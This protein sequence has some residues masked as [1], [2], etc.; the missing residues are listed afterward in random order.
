MEFAGKIETALLDLDAV[1]L[2]GSA[3]PFPFQA[4]EQA[5]AK[6]FQIKKVNINSEPPRW[7]NEKPQGSLASFFTLIATPLDVPFYLSFDPAEI[8]LIL[9]YLLHHDETALGLHDSTLRSSLIHFILAST[10][11][12]LGEAHY[13][14]NL[15]IRLAA[16]ESLPPNEVLRIDFSLL[17]D[18]EVV[19]GQLLLPPPFLTK[20][21]QH[22]FSVIPSKT[23]K[24][25]EVEI[26]LEGGQA[27]V[28]SEQWKSLKLGDILLLDSCTVSPN[29][30]QGLVALHLEGQTLMKGE[31]TDSGLQL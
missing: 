8:S 3:P 19:R 20:W 17:F 14:S 18:T 6:F 5:L 9:K 15:K 23:S 25:I 31:L 21:R 27:E 1:P 13:P 10:L 24:L 2:L 28:S 30:G 22:Y 7:T 11:A 16:H 12:L 26:G 29:T 4:L